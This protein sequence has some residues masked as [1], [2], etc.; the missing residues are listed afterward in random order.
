M[1]IFKLNVRFY[2]VLFSGYV[3]LFL[4]EIYNYLYKNL[5]I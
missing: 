1:T 5:H 2:L 4:I 3:E